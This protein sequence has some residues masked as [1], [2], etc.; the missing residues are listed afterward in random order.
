[1]IFIQHH[2]VKHLIRNHIHC[3]IFRTNPFHRRRGTRAKLTR[4]GRKIESFENKK[5][6]VQTE[7]KREETK[8]GNTKREIKL[9]RQRIA[10][11]KKACLWPACVSFC[12]TV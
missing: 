6:S 9:K 1:M 11:A 8:N 7:N 12:L 3:K 10:K 2:T 4:L 5:G